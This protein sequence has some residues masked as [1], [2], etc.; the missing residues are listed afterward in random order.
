MFHFPHKLQ[1][2]ERPNGFTDQGANKYI[3]CEGNVRCQ[4]MGLPLEIIQHSQFGEVSR[5]DAVFCIPGGV[6][7]EPDYRLVFEGTGYIVDR[8]QPAMTMSGRR[9]HSFVSTRKEMVKD[10]ASK[11]TET[12]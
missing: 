3:K 10:G 4:F 8:I 5:I 2:V 1:Q 6:K 9:L 7:V 12:L 11:Y